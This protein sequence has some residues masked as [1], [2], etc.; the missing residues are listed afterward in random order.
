M[1][2]YWEGIGEFNIRIQTL[3]T[4]NEANSLW[5]LWPKK[6]VVYDSFKNQYD[7]CSVWSFDP[8]NTAAPMMIEMM[9]LT[10]MKSIHLHLTHLPP[11]TKWSLGLSKPLTTDLVIH[12]WTFPKQM[13]LPFLR[14]NHRQIPIWNPLIM[15]HPMAHLLAFPALHHQYRRWTLLWRPMMKSGTRTL[16]CPPSLPDITPPL[17]KLTR[18]TSIT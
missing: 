5:G 9:N 13:H 14:S 17:M 15:P 7:C 2:Y 4:C 11:S 16:S 3:L 8:D 18:W 6:V 10:T 12:Q 1:V